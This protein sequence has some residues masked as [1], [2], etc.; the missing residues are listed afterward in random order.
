MQV[1]GFVFFILEKQEKGKPNPRLLRISCGFIHKKIRTV[2][3]TNEFNGFLQ[4]FHRNPKAFHF[5]PG[6][7]VENSNF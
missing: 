1:S 7:P 4:V 3:K 5:Y 2:E 6:K